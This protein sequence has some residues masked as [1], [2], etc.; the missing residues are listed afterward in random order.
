MVEALKEI[1]KNDIEAV[2]KSPQLSLSLLNCASKLL[3]NGKQPGVC[4]RSQRAYYNELKIKGMSKAKLL[5]EAKKRTC[6]PAWKGLAY[7]SKSGS[8]FSD[9]L[10]NDEQAIRALKNGFPE[11]KFE[12]LPEGYNKVVDVVKDTYN[13]GTKKKRNNKKA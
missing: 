13:K 11:S 3:L 12:V 9:E 4:S 6:V 10:I 2:I 1:F 5:E 8:H 7:H